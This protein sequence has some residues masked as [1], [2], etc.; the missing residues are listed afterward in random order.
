MKELPSA[1]RERLGEIALEISLIAAAREEDQVISPVRRRNPSVEEYRDDWWLNEARKL[2]DSRRNREKY[3]PAFFFGELAWNILIDLFIEHVR[4]RRVSIK[5]AT[6]A[7]GGPETTALRWIT[8]LNEEGL[9]D[10]QN[11]AT[12]RRRTWLS[13]TPKGSSLMKKYILSLNGKITD[14]PAELFLIRGG[15]TGN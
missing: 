3:F 5:S 11:S 13:M 4:G 7:S 12:D 14:Q 15:E 1:T 10:R 2:R 8:L 9:V 6:I